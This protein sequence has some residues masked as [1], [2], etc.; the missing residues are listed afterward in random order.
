MII[1]G[2][3]PTLRHVSRTHSV[4]L[5]WLFD[6][7]NL[8]SEDSNP[9]HWH[10]TLTRRHF[11]KKDT[12]PVTNGTIFFVCSTSAIAALCA[13]ARNFSLIS[14]TERMAKRMQEQ[15]RRKQDCGE[16]QAKGHKS[17]QF[18]CYKFFICERPNCVEKPRDT[19]SF[20][21]T[22]CIMLEVWCKHK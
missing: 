21:S 9:V 16:I 1:K 14:C 17:D 2:R 15:I 18:C 19:Q 6:R 7:I 10:Q 13:V 20:K 12:S 22:S 8:D 11:D 4:A 3:S 5:V